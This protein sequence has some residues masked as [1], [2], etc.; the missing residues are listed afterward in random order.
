MFKDISIHTCHMKIITCPEAGWN[1]TM[2][3]VRQKKRLLKVVQNVP[4]EE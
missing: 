4:P 1:A 2:S 3:K